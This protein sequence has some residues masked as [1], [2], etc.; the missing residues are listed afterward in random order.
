MVPLVLPW[1]NV[2]LVWTA[3]AV[4]LSVLAVPGKRAAAWLVLAGIVVY[5]VW[6]M[7][8]CM[9]VVAWYLAGSAVVLELPVVMGSRAA[10]PGMVQMPLVCNALAALVGKHMML[11]VARFAV[12]VLAVPCWSGWSSA[13][14]NWNAHLLG[15]SS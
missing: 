11:V 9:G 5:V 7:E 4:E 15:S 12:V 1:E 6:Q 8:E 13:C 14:R 2:A 10:F 3:L